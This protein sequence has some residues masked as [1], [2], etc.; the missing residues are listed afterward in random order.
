MTATVKIGAIKNGDRLELVPAEN[1]GW[2]VLSGEA[3]SRYLRPMV[4]AYSSSAD[5][6][7]ALSS[8]LNG[9]STESK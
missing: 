5:M 9:L 7:A 6:L 3:D 1:G 8:A 2:V 4:G